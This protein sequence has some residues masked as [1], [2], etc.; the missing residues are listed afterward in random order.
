M[1]NSIDFQT[2]QHPGGIAGPDEH[3][4]I[5]GGLFIVFEGIDGTGKSTQVGLLAEKLRQLGY[6][7]VATREPTDG[8][9]GQRIRKLFHD[10]AAVTR[11][12]E[13]ELFIA[14]R[15]QHV[16]QVIAPALAEG[17]VVISDRYYLSTVAYQ[18]A[19]GGDPELILRKNA[20]FPQP[21][22]AIIL[23]VDPARSI[24]RIKNQR[25]EKPNTFEGEENLRRVAGI[26][27][28]MDQDFIWRVDG[29]GSVEEVHGRAFGAVAELLVRKT[30]RIIKQKD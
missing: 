25:H 11:D 20:D 12:E 23:E 19:N 6:A 13:L 30:G 27:A 9:Y 5:P 4:R 10:R 7:V 28:A 8:P 16:R 18:G 26:F 3:L 15:T 21:D 14:D 24:H 29:T 2:G 17:R 1:N 22:L